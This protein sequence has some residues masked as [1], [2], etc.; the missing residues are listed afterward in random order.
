MISLH[1]SPCIETFDTT[2]P[3]YKTVCEKLAEAKKEL[4]SYIPQLLGVIRQNGASEF[5][6]NANAYKAL[7][8]KKFYSIDY[9]FSLDGTKFHHTTSIGYNENAPD[10]EALLACFDPKQEAARVRFVLDCLKQR[11]ENPAKFWMPRIVQEPVTE[12]N[13]RDFKTLLEHL[14]ATNTHTDIQNELIKRVEPPIAPQIITTTKKPYIETARDLV[15]RGQDY[16]TGEYKDPFKAEHCYWRALCLDPKYIPA[17]RDLALLIYSGQTCLDPTLEFSKKM[18]EEAYLVA[19]KNYDLNRALAEIYYYGSSTIAPNSAKAVMHLKACLKSKPKDE[20]VTRCLE[21]LKNRIN[22]D[23][24]EMK[25]ETAVRSIAL[26][27]AAKAVEA[28]PTRD[29]L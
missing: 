24:A 4:P 14:Q 9:Y 22:R 11:Q 29:I 25:E 28:Q 18:L 19:K 20:W 10:K 13:E 12:S 16:E 2:S 17:K 3:V 8:G 1:R 27:F 6:Y 15:K 5:L 7:N 21:H 23:E 26:L